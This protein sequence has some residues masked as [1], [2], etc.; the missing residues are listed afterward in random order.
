MT[1]TLA[2]LLLVAL[3]GL[4]GCSTSVFPSLPTGT[5]T[6]CDPA[7]PGRWQPSATQPGETQQPGVLDV[8]ADC[9]TATVKGDAKPMRLTLV[10]TGKARYLQLHNDSGEPDCIGQGKSRCGAA[11][12]RYEREGDKRTGRIG[13]VTKPVIAQV[14]GPAVGGGFG[15]CAGADIR[16]ATPEA[17]F[18]LPMA[19]TLG[20]CLSMAN[21][22]KFMEVLGGD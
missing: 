7:W 11:L 21:Y 8:S 17:R 6:D 15:I 9:R 3:L 20:N 13:R 19:R 4:A 16:I 18:G 5:T 1:R 12:L 10:D 14:E 2:G 22:A